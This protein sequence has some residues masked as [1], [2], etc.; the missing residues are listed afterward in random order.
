MKTNRPIP[1]TN[2]IS[3]F[4]HCAKCI[5][6]CPPT[7]PITQFERVELGMTSIGLQAWCKRHGN[8]IHVDFQGAKHPANCTR[9]EISP[10][11]SDLVSKALEGFYDKKG[12]RL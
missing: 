1:N 10:L 6:E 2:E 12:S 7:V 11:G 8:I 3:T 9:M 5:A 4:F